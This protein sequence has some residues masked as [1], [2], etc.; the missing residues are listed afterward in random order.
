MRF[1]TWLLLCCVAAGVP[2]RDLPG[3]PTAQER[4]QA[5]R[6]AIDARDW[7]AAITELEDA[8]FQEPR[9]ADAHNLLAYSYRKQ[10]AANLA[11]AFEHYRIALSL[12]PAHRGAHEYIGEAYLADR[13]P[14]EAERHLAALEKICGSR[15]CEEYLDLARAIAEYRKATRP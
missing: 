7:R 9:N 3:A 1:L 13:K 10:P 15:S 14:Q 4:L 12:D 6:A 8:V 5:A 2:A 11:K